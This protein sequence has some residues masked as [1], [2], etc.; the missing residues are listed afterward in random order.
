[1]MFIMECY[2]LGLGTQK[3][4]KT[5]PKAEPQNTSHT[6]SPEQHQR[7]DLLYQMNAFETPQSHH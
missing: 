6:L 7:N 2:L 5:K 3:K 4:K 1:M